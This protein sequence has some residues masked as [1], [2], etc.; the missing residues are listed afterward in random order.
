MGQSTP[1]SLQ[2]S[3]SILV[4]RV[5]ILGSPPTSFLVSFSDPRAHAE[6]EL[7][8]QFPT[9]NLGSFSDPNFGVVFRPS[10]P[11]RIRIYIVERKLVPFSDPN[12]GVGKRHQIWGRKLSQEFQFGAR[13]GVG[14]HSSGRAV[15][16]SAI[17]LLGRSLA[18]DWRHAREPLLAAPSVRPVAHGRAQRA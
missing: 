16:G 13:S 17:K 7:W 4:A 2:I 11:R 10:L 18:H 5:R 9:P 3:K 12:F 6:L 15:S 8:A 14:S 1:V